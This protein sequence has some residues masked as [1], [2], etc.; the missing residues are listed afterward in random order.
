VTPPR[1][2]EPKDVRQW[3]YLKGASAKLLNSIISFTTTKGKET[4]LNSAESFTLWNRS[5]SGSVDVSDFFSQYHFPK[6]QCLGLSGF[7]ISSWDLMESRTTSL[8]TLVLTNCK[9]SSLPT[10][11]QMLSILSANPSL[12]PLRLSHSSFPDV[13]SDGSSSQIQLPHLKSL[14]LGSGLDR[15]F[16]LSNRLELPDKMDDLNLTLPDYPPSDLSQT[17]VP[18]LGDRR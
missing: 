7:S 10:L 8:T 9:Q 13:D 5:M 17:V 14:N 2:F 15:A 18:Y 12:K 16:R 4:R 3:V 1:A 6:L 11:P